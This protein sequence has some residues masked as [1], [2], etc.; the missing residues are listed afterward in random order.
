MQNLGLCGSFIDDVLVVE[1]VNYFKMWKLKGV[2]LEELQQLWD[3]GL[4]SFV[5]SLRKFVSNLNSFLT[6]AGQ[7]FFY[8]SG[9][10][11]SYEY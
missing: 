4:E 1:V 7:L 6:F 11:K 5:V 8:G 2:F 10:W 9:S 3:L